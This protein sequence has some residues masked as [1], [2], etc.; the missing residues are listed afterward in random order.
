MMRGAERYWAHNM[1]DVTH[2]EH[3]P[4]QHSQPNCLHHLPEIMMS[5]SCVCICCLCCDAGAGG[6]WWLALGQELCPYCLELH[7]YGWLE[8]P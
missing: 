8:V 7:A 6:G 4:R 5:S 1:V 2:H 3:Q